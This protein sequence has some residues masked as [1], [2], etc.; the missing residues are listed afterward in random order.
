[1]WLLKNKKRILNDISLLILRNYF[2]FLML[3][4]IHQ[5]SSLKIITFYCHIL[6]NQE[7]ILCQ[8]CTRENHESFFLKKCFHKISDFSIE[9]LHQSERRSGPAW[10]L[11]SRADLYLFSVNFLSH[12]FACRVI[13]IEEVL[14][15]L[16]LVSC[17][18]TRTECLSG[19]QRKRLSVALELVNNP[20]VI[21]LDEPTTWVTVTSI[22]FTV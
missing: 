15:T 1:M 5:N 20:P 8:L 19:G 22:I 4:L 12:H 13:Q 14:T 16:G 3:K 11:V 18:N 7:L 6:Y 2:L 9:R 21:F 10:A 17:R